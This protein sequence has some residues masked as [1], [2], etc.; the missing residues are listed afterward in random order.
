MPLPAPPHVRGEIPVVPFLG[1]EVV[2]FVAASL[3]VPLLAVNH[4]PALKALDLHPRRSA[5]LAV[6]LVEG[7]MVGIR[8]GKRGV[9]VGLHVARSGTAGEG[10]TNSG[11]NKGN[12][13]VTGAVEDAPHGVVSHTD[14]LE[15]VTSV[16]EVERI[17][18]K[19]VAAP[20]V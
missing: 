18:T 17:I 8:H 15:T 4:A 11:G 19:F 10:K 20:A 1:Y 14:T 5:H 16:G 7:F 3:K 2:E 12:P 13:N 6:Y 9:G